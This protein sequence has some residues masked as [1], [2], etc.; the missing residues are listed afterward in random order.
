MVAFLNPA[1]IFVVSV[2]CW[3]TRGFDYSAAPSR[4]DFHNAI[5]IL[6]NNP[7]PDPLNSQKMEVLMVDFLLDITPEFFYTVEIRWEWRKSSER[8]PSGTLSRWTMLFSVMPGTEHCL[9][10]RSG[11]PVHP[12]EG[13]NRA[14][15]TFSAKNLLLVFVRVDTFRAKPSRSWRAATTDCSGKCRDKWGTKYGRPVNLLARHRSKARRSL[16]RESGEG[17]YIF[18]HLSF[19]VHFVD[20]GCI[21]ANGLYYW[22]FLDIQWFI[23]SPLKKKPKPVH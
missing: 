22:W 23:K 13:F 4:H 15:N 1:G 20:I 9:I 11:A 7:L 2:F 12:L 16:R 17:R 14:F 19:L 6:L 18:V 8:S 5:T 10:S 3:A 21:V